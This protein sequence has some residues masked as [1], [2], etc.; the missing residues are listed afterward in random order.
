LTT[1]PSEKGIAASSNI[2]TQTALYSSFVF[3][4]H[5]AAMRLDFSRI[6]I[7]IKDTGILSKFV[8]SGLSFSPFHYFSAK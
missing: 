6:D 1:F 3:Y 7:V 4:Q 8:I 2:L 5:V